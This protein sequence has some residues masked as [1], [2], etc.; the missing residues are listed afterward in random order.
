MQDLEGKL[1]VALERMDNLWQALAMIDFGMLFSQLKHELGSFIKALFEEVT[2][3]SDER[4]ACRMSYLAGNIVGFLVEFV[5]ELLLTGGVS[6]VTK[7]FTAIGEIGAK[8]LNIIP[9]L[10]KGIME[11]SVEKV[12]R[13]TVDTIELIVKLASTKAEALAEFIKQLFRELRSLLGIGLK[14]E[15][16]EALEKA[17]LT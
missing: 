1:P 9:R 17:G 3:G 11:I 15:A 13:S 14:R 12:A 4:M 10:L 7:F 2:G 16:E 6:A 5:I 8:L